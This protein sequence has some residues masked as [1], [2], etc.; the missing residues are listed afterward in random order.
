MKQLTALTLALLLAGCGRDPGYQAYKA[1]MAE[2]LSKLQYVDA[3]GAVINRPDFTAD[4][5]HLPDFAAIEDT[6]ERKQAFF[7]YLRPAVEY[8]NALN[9]ER[10]LLL[11]AVKL[12][13]K[14]GMPLSGADQ[15]F[16][17]DMALRYRVP[18][19]L[20]VDEMVLVLER[21]LDIIPASMVLAQA[22]LESG[23]GTSRFAKEANN[24]FGQWCFEEGCGL[25]PSNRRQGAKH[26]VAAFETVDAA[27]A[28]Y[29]RNIN[30][31][32]VYEPA[33][34]IREAARSEAGSLS[35]TQMAEGLL[36]YSERGEDYI[37]EVRAVIRINGLEGPGA[38]EAPRSG[39][40]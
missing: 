37:D 7:E 8:R 13:L 1:Y 22:A 5:S 18:E 20:T 4:Y 30:T 32:P 28:S 9:E 14:H 2:H 39:R 11:G 36:R 33:R 27:I 17:A 38:T 15:Q 23:W 40:G 19:G 6:R 24:L 34:D 16:V 3:A 25:V 21:R 31:H 26:E 29:F 12:R 10:R 35:G